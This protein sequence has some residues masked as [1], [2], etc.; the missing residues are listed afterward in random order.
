MIEDLA[1]FLAHAIRLEAD[2]A[3]GYD[4]LAAR[5]DEQG[6]AGA[7]ALFRKLGEFSC[8]HLAETHARYRLL[9][10]ECLKLP[11]SEYR[12]PDGDSPEDPRST[13]P[14]TAIDSRQAIEMALGLERDACDFYSAVANQSRNAEVQELAQ[15]FAEEESEHVSQLERWLQRLPTA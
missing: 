5:M 1:T 11:D 8:L 12:W 9:V 3:D 14:D 10:G 4:W 13:H 15:T 6:N 7:A 2:A